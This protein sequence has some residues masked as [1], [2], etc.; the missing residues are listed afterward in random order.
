MTYASVKFQWQKDGKTYDYIIPDG[1]SVAPG[2]KVI[3]ETRRGETEVEVVAVKDES[4]MASAYIVRKA[5]PK[6][7]EEMDF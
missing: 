3:V 7:V 1:M 6:I 5:E 4:E 2:D